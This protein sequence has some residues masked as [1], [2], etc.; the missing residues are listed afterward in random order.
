MLEITLRVPD[1]FTRLP[2]AERDRLIRAGLHEAVRARI[3]QLGSE[4]AQSKEEIA[5][6]EERYGMPLARFEREV[7]PQDESFQ[8]HDDYTDWTYWPSVLEEKQQLLRDLAA[9][10]A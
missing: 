9:L 7:L 3:R 10:E 1:A 4:I 8:A 2:E 6:F 5:R